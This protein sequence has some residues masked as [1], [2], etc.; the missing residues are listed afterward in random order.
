MK[1]HLRICWLAHYPVT[2]LENE[3]SWGRKRTVGHACSWV[4]N[5]ARALGARSDVELHVVSLC[6]WVRR[7]QTFEHPDR[8]TLHVIKSGVPLLHKGFPWFFQWDAFSGYSSERRS[9]LRKVNEIRPDLI[10]AHG[11]EYAYGL[12]AMDA[13]LPWVVSIQGIMSEL[14]KVT[15]TYSFRRR[16]HLERRVVSRGQ[17]F[18]GRTQY[19]HEFIRRVNPAAHIFNIPEAMHPAFF[20]T[21]WADPSGH[22]VLFVGSMLKHKGLPC[23]L[24]ALGLVVKDV[25]DLEFEVAGA[26]TPEE[27]QQIAARLASAGMKNQP[28]FHGFLAPAALAALHRR[29]RLFVL[30]SLNENS[31]NVL[32]EA[33]VSGMPVVAHDV[34]GVSSLFEH[35]L[36]GLLVP[37]GDTAAMAEAMSRIL[38]SGDLR[39]RLSSNARALSSRNHPQRVAEVTM[40]AYRD[41]LGVA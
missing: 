33:L 16:A 25:P 13:G 21:P 20:E 29:C 26:F 18:M 7:D 36:S 38:T 9:L 4:V 22:R 6:P 1:Q 39:A 8:Y 23:L 31:P 15:A 32:A 24:D 2:Q 35:G 37:C 5:L 17:Y 34:G 40:S 30:P 12:A 11:T 14:E 19:D 3:L 41:M 28:A 10:H 27:Q